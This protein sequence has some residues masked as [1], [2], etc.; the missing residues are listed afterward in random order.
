MK[1][2]T[3]GA[4]TLIRYL[5]QEGVRYVFGMPGSPLGPLFDRLHDSGVKP[6]LIKHETCAAFIADGYARFSGRIGVCIG[7]T[8]PGVTNLVT[9][10]ATAFADGIPLLV[11]TGQVPTTVFGKGAFQESTT[12]TFGAT[13]LLRSVT[14]MSEMVIEASLLPRLLKRALRLAQTGKTGP[15]A[16][17]F[18]VNVL[19]ATVT[20]DV[21]ESPYDYRT[22]NRP[23]DRRMVARGAKALMAAEKPVILAGSGVSASGAEA[24]LLALAEQLRIPVATTPKAKGCFPEDH[25]LSLGIFGFAGH[26]RA[27]RYVQREADLVLV[28]ASSLGQWQ[29]DNYC[30]ALEGKALVQIDIDAAELGKN[31]PIQVGLQG[32]AQVVLKE[33]RYSI[34]RELNKQPAGARRPRDSALEALKREVPRFVDESQMFS[35]A[36]PLAPQCVMRELRLALPRDTIV[37]FDTGAHMIWGLHYFDAY[38]P[39]TFV[40]SSGLCTMGYGLAAAIG[41]KLAVPER[42]VV[43]VVGDGCFLMQGMEVHTAVEY[44]VPVVWVV[45]N[46]N[47]LG[48]VAQGQAGAFGRSTCAT[49]RTPVNFA[50]LARELGAE[51]FRVERPEELRRTIDRALAT[52]RPSV[53]DVVIDPAQRPPAKTNAN[54]VKS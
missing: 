45:M 16:L 39:K 44:G 24:E 35:T 17:N 36:T 11:I 53:I 10:V 47:E 32:D 25:P 46:N 33:L 13:E 7:T 21:H 2:A 50:A 14:K 52:G 26:P 54:V 38:V 28:A 34:E 49:Y 42:T 9:G 43:S 30:E 22:R 31:Y 4:D 20:D 5:E 18:P 29:T 19:A 1:L 6:I 3:S 37:F 8:G 40:L 41:A 15:V 12:S 48:M 51:G 27:D 23:F